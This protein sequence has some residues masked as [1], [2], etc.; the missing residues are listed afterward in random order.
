MRQFKKIKAVVF[1]WSGTV[2][3][4]GCQA[5]LAVIMR[6]FESKGIP[7]TVDEASGPMGM[8]KID[9]F[10][11]LFKLDRVKEQ[12][13]KKY[14][15]EAD[16]NS[17]LEFYSLFE[18][19]LFQILP[20]YSTPIPGVV[21]VIE[22][23]RNKYKLKIGST[24]GFTK[25]MLDYVHPI[26]KKH[27]YSPDFMITSSEVLRG[28]PYPYML[29]QNAANLDIPGLELMIKIGDT[30]VDIEEGQNAGCWSGALIDGSSTLGYSL[31]D[32]KKEDVNVLNK[33]REYVRQVY[34]SKNADFILNNM[35]ELPEQIEKINE[36][37][38]KG[39]LP[40]NKFEYPAESHSKRFEFI[41]EVE[42]IKKRMLI[43]TKH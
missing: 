28:R 12:Y 34:K 14:G 29:Y 21:N 11:E 6:I 38:A 19:M 26:A 39:E 25:P 35:S 15:K 37:L 17:I 4:F 16:D 3:D 24:T 31:E 2:V 23:L 30:T 8:L 18:P 13:I 33:R 32:F 10:R 22:E 43:D 42:Q 1:D 27:G 40:N 41:S 20:D 36:K 5:P 7:L 9:H